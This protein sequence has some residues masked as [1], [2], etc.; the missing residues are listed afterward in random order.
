MNWLDA[1]KCSV[2]YVI[3]QVVGAAAAKDGHGTLASE[4]RLLRKFTELAFDETAEMR[5]QESRP[6]EADNMDVG[7]ATETDW[8]SNL[9]EASGNPF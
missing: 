7:P 5:W 8:Q 1:A 3:E 2:L 6:A 9:M 4:R